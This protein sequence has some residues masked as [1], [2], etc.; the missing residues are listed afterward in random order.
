MDCIDFT[1]RVDYLGKASFLLRPPLGRRLCSRQP[2]LVGHTLCKTLFMISIGGGEPRYRKIL[3]NLRHSSR[4]SVKHCTGGCAKDGFATAENDGCV[5]HNLQIQTAD[6]E[7][8]GRVTI[9]G[10]F[11]KEITLVRK[12]DH[13]LR[14]KHII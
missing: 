13:F 4:S 10:D 3:H 12:C 9:D 11:W 8:T 1:F 2:R 5:V 14:L 6:Q 7:D